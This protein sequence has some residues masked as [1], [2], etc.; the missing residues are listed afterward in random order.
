MKTLARISISLFLAMVVL[1]GAFMVVYT[2][3]VQVGTVVCWTAVV[4]AVVSM[5]CLIGAGIHSLIFR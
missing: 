3:P 5:V 4:L 1:A 2:W